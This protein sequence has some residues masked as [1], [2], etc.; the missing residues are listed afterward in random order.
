LKYV[1]SKAI[2][3]LSLSIIGLMLLLTI[4][5]ILFSF[6]DSY[7][8]KNHTNI[9]AIVSKIIQHPVAVA[10]ISSSNNGLDPALTLHNVVVYDKAKTKKI[11]QAQKLQVGIDLIGS[12]LSWRIKPGLLTISTVN[13]SFDLT[14]PMISSFHAKTSGIQNSHN[15]II[16]PE[17]SDSIKDKRL[18]LNKIKKLD[19]KDFAARRQILHEQ[20]PNTDDFSWDD[21][22][23]FYWLFEQNKI[24]LKGVN[25]NLRLANGQIIEFN[26]L[27]LKLYNDSLQHKL[28][29]SGVFLQKTISNKV[30]LAPIKSPRGE[31][32]KTQKDLGPGVS[33]GKLD[34][35]QKTI[36]SRFTINLK[37]RALPIDS[38]LS[39]LIKIEDLVLNIPDKTADSDLPIPYDLIP[40]N[41]NIDI[42]I[43]NS[44]I[45]ANIFQ[46]KVPIDNFSS[47]LVW[48]NVKNSGQTISKKSSLQELF[49]KNL[50]S[51]WRALF[52]KQ[53]RGIPGLPHPVKNM[54]LAMTDTE[55]VVA[56]SNELN[57]NLSELKLISG[58]LALS[59]DIK[60]SSPITKFDPTVD[61]NIDF[62]LE[63]LT[64]AK[65]YYPTKLMP[66]D[67]VVWLK[68]A[69]ASSEP[70]FGKV[71]FKG[72]LVKFPF[73]NKEGVFFVDANIN[74]VHL[75]YDKNWPA[76]KNITGKLIFSNRAME[77]LAH[78]AK[79]M[80]SNID[81]V[82]AFIPDLN[83]PILSVDSTIN[84]ESQ[85]GL[86]FINSSPL[87]ANLGEKLKHISLRGPMQLGL[88]L[89]IP[90][91]DS[92]LNQ[93][94]QVK[95]NVRLH[96]NY[97]YPRDF[98]FGI[99]GLAGELIFTQDALFAKNLHGEL[100][101]QPVNINID[102]IS[103]ANKE[104]LTKIT[105]HGK[106]E[107]KDVAAG[108][109]IN[110]DASI[111][112]AAKYQALFEIH[113]TLAKN[114]FLQVDSD[115]QGISIDLP[116][117]LFKNASS[118][119]KSS[120]IYYFSEA[121]TPK[122][123]IKYGDQITASFDKNKNLS[124]DISKLDVSL[125]GDYLSR[126]KTTTSNKSGAIFNSLIL[127][128]NK[129]NALGQTLSKVLLQINKEEQNWRI[130]IAALPEIKGSILISKNPDMQISGIFEQLQIN[131]TSDAKKFTSNI[132]PQN[133]APLDFIIENFSY[134]NKNF[135]KIYL[136]TR[137]QSDGM[138]I[139][140]LN[141][142]HPDFKVQASGNW[143]KQQ[144][145]L[146]G[147]LH[148]QNAGNLLTSLN[149]N[150]NVIGGNGGANFELNW[151]QAPYDFSLKKLTGKFN[152][153]L[154][155]GYI[156]NLGSRTEIKLGV[157]KALNALSLRNLS[158][159]ITSITKKGLKFDKFN[160]DAEIKN[161]NI[162]IKFL[163]LE[164]PIAKVVASGL[165][166]LIAKD[167]NMY[168]N[169]IPHITS[170]VPIA[171]TF[172][173]GPI[174]GLISWVV[175]DVVVAPVIKKATTY[176]YHVTGSWDDPTMEKIR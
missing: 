56:N 127:K 72:S 17:K 11:I 119:K 125:W 1:V 57:I 137:P 154:K 171:A 95:G 158:S 83:K 78:N 77:I 29:I 102:T 109:D 25:I 48:Q 151:P 134:N 30:I 88:K 93:E 18:Q 58:D 3:I 135:N 22:K 52:A 115:L 69:F 132:K 27:K 44:Q 99:N 106:A 123:I 157:G 161:G 122:A 47:N 128:I 129:L 42:S 142:E 98:N 38:S 43:K 71:V 139:S 76:I 126:L 159:D 31:A 51:S 124:T 15:L 94:T 148:T 162:V 84:S 92:I 62:F 87:K 28:K 2:N 75:N 116:A 131:S 16:K 136:T 112:G 23:E 144:T 130:N 26:D 6:S 165:I 41:G 33:L 35:Q 53:S 175:A 10:Q 176:K 110:L 168:V 104:V 107:A 100:F 121:R 55:P 117:P 61:A 24:Y 89:L 14:A 68:N 54:G 66:K 67:A 147:K 60:I 111:K 4:F 174:I 164:G 153:E 12:L 45:I 81:S 7:L 5:L 96:D 103:A 108:F 73:D 101:K 163:K 172:A 8:E 97:L 65:L 105:L 70:M 173:A 156:V 74:N 149:I 113:N 50:I 79:I 133:I 86:K 141:I 34:R 64:K 91:D 82:R 49:A 59:G 166:G 21:V 143:I 20:L 32:H 13:L 118:N 37:L 150:N 85:L 160:T 145:S 114:S 138:E 46:N 152:V 167:Y 40:L 169:V 90:L 146:H 170:S 19:S 63:N 140:K 120:F 80:Q 9:E 36:P 39:G 155:K